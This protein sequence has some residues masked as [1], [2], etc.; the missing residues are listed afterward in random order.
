METRPTWSRVDEILAALPQ[1]VIEVD[2][3][4]NIKY[5]N[6]PVAPFLIHPV[7]AGDSLIAALP[8][9]AA[10]AIV[11]TVDNAQRIG[12][13]L[14]EYRAENTVYGV[15]A[16]PL[17]STEGTLLVIE[18][19]SQFDGRGATVRELLRDHHRFLSA[20]RY[21]IAN[22]LSAVT[23]C[24]GV[25]V[26]SGPDFNEE[27]REALLRH[28]S[29]QTQN[30]TATLEDLRTAI[31]I[32]LG[33]LEM[34]KMPF[35]AVH[36]VHFAVEALGSRADSINVTHDELV[37]VVGD[38]VRY[39]QIVRS[40]LTNSLSH[41]PGP[42]AVNIGSADGHAVLTVNDEEE[43]VSS[44]SSVTPD[45]RSAGY[46]ATSRKVG[47][48]LWVARELAKAMGGSLKLEHSGGEIRFRLAIP[49]S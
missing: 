26:D 37:E 45:S 27:A 29:E 41:R 5:I 34:V 7:S 25:L 20:I 14:S 11:D 17:D 2:S 32:E 49:A 35:D 8:A 22:P 10:D 6:R 36:S 39:G 13:S 24:A 28:M 30:L 3:D 31:T 19:A 42:I 48:G 12:R 15:S 18:S 9:A 44:V 21:D 16:K 33:Q 46:P 40:L 38:R 47:L 23:G 1:I 43:S 4:L